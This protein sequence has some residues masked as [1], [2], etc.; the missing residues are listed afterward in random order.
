MT[1]NPKKITEDF[2][3]VVI[4]VGLILSLAATYLQLYAAYAIF[5]LL[6]LLAFRV[7]QVKKQTIFLKRKAKVSSS[8]WEQYW[9]DRTYVINKVNSGSI[10]STQELRARMN[11]LIEIL[12]RIGF[13]NCEKALTIGAVWTNGIATPVEL[14]KIGSLWLETTF[15]KSDIDS[16]YK[17]LTDATVLLPAKTF[18]KTDTDVC[19]ITNLDKVDVAIENLLRIK[20]PKE[21]EHWKQSG[22]VNSAKKLLMDFAAGKTDHMLWSFSPNGTVEIVQPRYPGEAIEYLEPEIYPGKVLE[23]VKKA[24]SRLLISLEYGTGITKGLLE[25]II[26]KIEEGI[27]I[28]VC[29]ATKPFSNSS[30][31][32]AEKEWEKTNEILKSLKEHGN[33]VIYEVPEPYHSW[34]MWLSVEDNNPVEGIGFFRNGSLPFWHETY[35][36]ESTKATKTLRDLYG[37]WKEMTENGHWCKKYW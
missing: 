23:I 26:W 4:I 1:T 14:A 9:S 28:E 33:V 24:S 16:A 2:V 18:P 15:E 7:Y 17:S 20:F 35:Y 25:K 3:I 27:T 8:D 10:L 5:F 29:I 6:I 34:H 32:E 22:L 31:S 30:G 11:S 21:S 13:E 12:G 37:H 36:A 19:L